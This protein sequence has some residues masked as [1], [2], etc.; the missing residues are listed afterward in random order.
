MAVK[1]VE[2]SDETFAALE[3]LAAA[4]KSTPTEIIAA[5]VGEHDPAPLAGDQLLFFLARPDFAAL[6]DPSERY[7]ALLAWVAQHHACDFADFISHQDSALRYLA[8][9]PEEVQGIRAR[10]HARQIAG[11]HYWAVMTIGD[12]T[13]ARF[14]RRLLEFVGCPDDAVDAAL[15]ALGLP[16]REPVFR[17]LSA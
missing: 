14:V 10:N 12:A 3:R 4:G 16:L 7:L 15:R 2:L 13:K 6:A 1:T 9:G 5:L 11:T 8:L 17:L